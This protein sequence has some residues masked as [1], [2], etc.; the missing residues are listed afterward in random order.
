MDIEKYWEKAL[1]ET[2]IIRSRVKSLQ[3]DHA[4][5][6]PYILLSESTINIGDTVVRTGEVL[7]DKPALIV[8][9]NNPMFSGFDFDAQEDSFSENS[10][11]NFLIVR[12]VSLPSLRY[13]NRTS[14]L[15]IFEGG[16]ADAIKNYQKN[17]EMK[18]NTSTGLLKSSEE[19][20]PLSLL[21]FICVQ[22][23][24]NANQDIRRLM[25]EYH[26]RKDS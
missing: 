15:D 23:A 3:S 17:L 20:W 7:I 22:V 5:R 13:D 4:T 24:R 16:L 2:E 12:G 21:I 8:P 11:V 6:V 9:P 1:K 19:C 26:R 14:S 18:E 10:L 25:D